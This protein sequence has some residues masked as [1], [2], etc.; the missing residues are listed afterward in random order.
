[1]EVL[2]SIGRKRKIEAIGLNTIISKIDPVHFSCEQKRAL[3]KAKE[4]HFCP[5]KI[6]EPPNGVIDLLIG[7]NYAKLHPAPVTRVGSLVLYQTCLQPIN[8]VILAG[9]L[10]DLKEQDDASFQNTL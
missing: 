7:M 6:I 10:M 3:E 8:N 1:M 2:D 5:H 4:E 9:R